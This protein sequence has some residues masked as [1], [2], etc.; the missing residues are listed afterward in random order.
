MGRP[1]YAPLGFRDEYE[2]SRYEGE[3]PVWKSAGAMP[4]EPLVRGVEGEM[5]ALDT[6]AFGAGRPDVLVSLAGRD[7][8]LCWLVRD[9]AGRPGGYLIAREGAQ[10]VQIGPWVAQSAE[11][12][13]ALLAA[14]FGRLPGRRVLVDV[15][16]PN[17]A[18]LALMQRCG[19][20]VQRSF[21]RMYLGKNLVPGRPH[22]VYGTSGAEKG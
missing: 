17:G 15:P 9:A 2:L 4:V 16:C 14:L 10:A 20:V 6:A 3:V 8:G 11:M 22:E 1:V 5:A 7:P 13:E 21:T 19:F 12:A 18:R